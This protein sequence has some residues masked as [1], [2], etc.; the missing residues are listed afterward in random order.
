MDKPTP[1]RSIRLRVILQITAAVLAAACIVGWSLD[2]Y[3]RRDFSRTR[4]F[5][6]SNQTR[7]VLWNLG[8]PAKI[9][10]LFSPSSLATGS[11]LFGDITALLREYQF[12]SHHYR[13]LT[14]E[15][16]D[17][18][19]DPGRARDLQAR[20]K[21][22]GSENVLIVDY[23]DRNKVIP[24]PEMGE[25][26]PSP[27]KYGEQPRLIAFRGEQVL[28]SALIGLVEPASNKKVYFLQ[29]H[30]EMLPGV[31]PV[32]LLGQNLKRQNLNIAPLSLG[33]GETIPKDAA[34]VAVA[35]AHFDLSEP[36]LAALKTY[37]KAGGRLL[38]LIDPTGSTPSLDGFL[39]EAGITP[40]NDRVLRLVNLGTAT[41]ILRDVT[42]ECFA[43][44]NI[45]ARLMGV[46]ILFAGSTMSLAIKGQVGATGDQEHPARPLVRAIHGFR[47]CTHHENADGKGVSFDPVKDN[48]FPVIIAAMADLGGPQDDRVSMGAS[49]MVVFGN[50]DFVKDKFLV[51]PGLDLLSSTINSLVDRTRLTGTTPKTKEFFTLNLDE[52]QLRLLALWAMGGV[53]LATALL[54][55]MVLWRRRS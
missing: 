32:Q 30:G 5:E 14:V 11:E 38:V 16:V 22:S 21:L 13:D 19:R 40:R 52:A 47:G 24:V 20:Y 36:E 44:S 25:Y 31:P 42:G 43:G 9:I 54:G 35:G 18:S 15:F 8:A 39:S 29:G 3:V 6:V 7:E 34:L 10:L 2:H 27:V 28:T 45:T 33:P 55:A 50:C 26:D 46:N 41:G 12:L 49:R 23:K 1:L 53:P 4:K 48:F 37:W 17:P 51:G